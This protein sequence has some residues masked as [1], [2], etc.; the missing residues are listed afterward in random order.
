MI[1]HEMDNKMA[2][3]DI[4]NEEQYK[5]AA[6]RLKDFFKENK[7]LL[8]K[9]YNKKT[10]KYSFDEIIDE[11]K[12]D[13]IYLKFLNSFSLDKLSG[14]KEKEEDILTKFLFQSGNKND[15]CHEL[16]FNTKELGDIRGGNVY[17][18]GIYK[19]KSGWILGYSSNKHRSINEKEAINIGRERIDLLIKGGEI[20]ESYNKNTTLINNWDLLEEDFKKVNILNKL[21]S[22]VWVRKYYHMLYPK[23]LS[24]WFSEKK[25]DKIL[26]D[27]KI[28]PLKTYYGK[29]HQ[30]SLIYNATGFNPILCGYIC[31]SIS[32]ID[33]DEDDENEDSEEINENSEEKN[34]ES[35][36]LNQILYGPPGTGKT[37]N[38]VIK[39][40]E[41]IDKYCIKYDSDNGNG[42]VINYEDIKKNFD[43]A[44]KDGRIEFIT[45]H[46]SY[47]YEEFVEGIKPNLEDWGNPS[48]KLT[49]KGED[50]IFKK[51][52]NRALFDRLEIK[53]DKKNKILNF[54]FIIE[55]FKEKHQVDEVL[56]TFKSQSK[57]KIEKYTENSLRIRPLNSENVFSI[58]FDY[59][60]DAFNK[61][62]QKDEDIVNIIGMPKGLSTY[63]RSIYSEFMDIYYTEVKHKSESERKTVSNPDEISNENKTKLVKDFYNRRISLKE[64]VNDSKPYVLIIDEINRGNISKIFGELI[65]LIEEDK[66]ES[67]SVRLPYSHE[68][69][70]VPKNLYIIGTMNTSDRSIA[71]IDIALRRR[72]TFKEMMPN[73]DRVP[74]ITIFG[75]N[76]RDI[77]N[78]INKRI[79]VLLDRDHQ[80]GHSYFMKLDGYSDEKQINK[81]FQRIWFEDIMPLLNEYFYND[82]E[83]LRALLGEPNLNGGKWFSFIKEIKAIEF[84]N[85]YEIDVGEQY[86][87]VSDTEIDFEKA[88]KN[89]FTKKTS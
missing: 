66:R 71:S 82:W 43:K 83:K 73:Q 7:E 56:N 29:S 44:K 69:F 27:L 12:V 54:E 65:T 1:C 18:Y 23:Y 88:L 22:Y 79:S 58:S 33:K 28:K 60:E 68:E 25:L 84:A 75:L 9:N 77:F 49:Y 36:P 13:D 45:F 62:L 64:N 48:D 89:A 39:A 6:E 67:F 41:I 47:A 52:A 16:E 10:K 80:I 4:N 8:V 19:D 59:L 50:G 42:N 87:F 63:Y 20:I 46:Q 40:M 21:S 81:E 5:I 55:K 57:F 85:K 70:T 38:T 76:L 14:F 11:Q 35:F 31:A 78:K 17:K 26:K 74:D 34:M 15:L 30:L 24:N 2:D 53:E 32:H 86:D 3:N 37:Y 61:N 51:I 72:F